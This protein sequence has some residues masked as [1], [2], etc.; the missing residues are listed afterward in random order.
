MSTIY[1]KYTQKIP[2]YADIYTEYC[3]VCMIRAGLQCKAVLWVHKS[4]KYIIDKVIHRE[5]W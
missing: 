4:Q 1:T 2:I 3:C 5:F